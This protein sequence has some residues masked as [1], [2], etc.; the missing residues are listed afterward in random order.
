M[1]KAYRYVFYEGAAA[2]RRR[3]W[4][5]AHGYEVT[6]TRPERRKQR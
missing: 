5:R 6:D 2:E 4:L 1:V 3:E